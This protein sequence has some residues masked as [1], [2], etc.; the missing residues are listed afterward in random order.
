MPRLKFTARSID[1]LRSADGQQV[2]FWDQDHPGFGIR[3]AAGG[4]KT[5]IVM[6][7]HKGRLRRAS[8][9]RYPALSLADARDEALQTMA[10]VSKGQDPAAERRAI[11]A[12]SRDTVSSLA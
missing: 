12:P 4:R 8:L 10:R 6:Y 3:V 7:R 9:G 5:W 1:S 2:D 11:K